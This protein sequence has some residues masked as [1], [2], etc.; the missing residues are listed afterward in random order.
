MNTTLLARTVALSAAAVFAG[1]WLAGCAADSATSQRST[2]QVVDDSTITARVK[3][4]LANKEGIGKALD[5]NVT[6]YQGTVQLSGFIP[7]PEL[8]DRAATTARGV[9]GVRAV[10]NDLIVQSYPAAAGS[11]GR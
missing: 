7:S 1:A 11:S 6:T 4:A 2:G 5:I 9:D 10:K 8:A 3:T